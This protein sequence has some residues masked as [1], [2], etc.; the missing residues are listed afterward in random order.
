MDGESRTHPAFCSKLPALVLLVAAVALSLLVF[1]RFYAISP[2]QL[3][4]RWDMRVLHEELPNGTLPKPIVDTTSSNV[5]MLTIAY[6]PMPEARDKRWH[7]MYWVALANKGAYADAHGHP[8]YISCRSRLAKSRHSAWDKLLAIQ[9]VLQH[10]KTEWVW[11]S[12]AVPGNHG[13]MYL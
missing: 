6:L 10:A 2:S 1:P 7:L 8:L 4:V 11:V 3:Y 12:G 9:A 5:A 13:A